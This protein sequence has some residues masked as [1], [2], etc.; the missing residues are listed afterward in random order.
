[1]VLERKRLDIKR[2]SSVENK[3]DI[4]TSNTFGLI[5]VILINRIIISLQRLLTLC[6]SGT[7]IQRNAMCFC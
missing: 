4:I 1:M 2:F 6:F 7:V 5:Y 3:L